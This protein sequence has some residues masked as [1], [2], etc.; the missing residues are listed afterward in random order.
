MRWTASSMIYPGHGKSFSSKQTSSII[1]DQPEPALLVSVSLSCH[2]ETVRYM[3]GCQSQGGGSMSASILVAYATRYG[4][5]REVAE[6]VASTLR[7]AGLEVDIRPMCKVDA[8][9]GYRAVVMGAPLYTFC[10][11]RDALEFLEKHRE[12]LA[13]RPV[14]VFALGPFED[15][16]KEWREVRAQ[17]EE[18]LA[19]FPWL[20]PLATEVF[21][22][23][24]DP[25]KLS[26]PWSLLAGM[27]T[28]PATDIRDWAAIA[29]WARNLSTRLELAPPHDLHAE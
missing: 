2:D 22:G 9:G 23:K 17:L 18:E 29:A 6:A 20:R 21:G 13:S 10:W 27:R 15:E 3:A 16:E 7:A 5:T 24:F 25:A 1:S 8:L 28:V 26:L 12:A 4:S 19:K 11:H 14:A